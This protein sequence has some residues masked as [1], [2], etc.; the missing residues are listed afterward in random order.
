MIWE[1]C[2]RELVVPMVTVIAGVDVRRS[3]TGNKLDEAGSTAGQVKAAVPP[4][5][6]YDVGTN[7]DKTPAPPPPGSPMPPLVGGGGGSVGGGHI[8][9][10]GGA[11]RQ[12]P[13]LADPAVG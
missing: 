13:A 5:Q 6:G 2:L 10:A 9:G 3:R 1:G 4:P 8:V 11:Q 7:L 12:G